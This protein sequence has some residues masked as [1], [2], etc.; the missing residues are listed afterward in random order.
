MISSELFVSDSVQRWVSSVESL[1]VSTLPLQRHT[2]KKLITQTYKRQWWI[3]Y[4]HFE[5]RGNILH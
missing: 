5:Q 3:H 2:R 4:V 1:F